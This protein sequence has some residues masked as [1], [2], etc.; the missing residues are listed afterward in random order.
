VFVE[1]LVLM[2][3]VGCGTP[4]ASPPSGSTEDPTSP[5]SESTA[6][7][8]PQTWF[9]DLDGD[10]A[11]DPLSATQACDQPP[12]HTL[13][14][15]DCDDT[16]EALNRD[17]GDG[18]GHSSCD[19]DCDDADPELTAYDVDG[20]GYS[21]CAGDCHDADAALTPEDVDGD[22]A[23]SCAGDC[24]DADATMSLADADGDGASSCAGDC[25]DSDPLLSL[26]DVDGDGASSCAGDCDDTDPELSVADVDGDGLSSCAGDCDDHDA[27]S[28]LDR[29][30]DGFAACDGDC[31]DRDAAMSP[32]D[33]DG[34][35]YSTCDG[36]CDDTMALW[37]PLNG[38]VPTR[39]AAV[40]VTG[41]PGAGDLKQS[42]ALLDLDGDSSLDLLVRTDESPSSETLADGAYLFSGPLA[43]RD[44]HSQ[45]ALFYGSLAH[46]M[47]GYDIEAL[48][49]VNG[50]GFDDAAISTPLTTSTLGFTYLLHG[51][52]TP[53]TGPTDLQTLPV[54]WLEADRA[55]YYYDLPQPRG[56]G[57]LDRDGFDDYAMLHDTAIRGDEET[58]TIYLVHGAADAMMGTRSVDEAD[59]EWHGR[60]GESERLGGDIAA[61]DLNGDD[62]ADLVMGASRAWAGGPGLQGRAYVAYGSAARQVGVYSVDDADAH[63]VGT[64]WNGYYGSR[65]EADFDLDADGLDDFSVGEIYASNLYE[66]ALHFYRGSDAWS[67]GYAGDT[68]AWLTVTGQAEY[69]YMGEDSAVAD[70][71][72]D[73][74]VDLAVSAT[75]LD[76]RRG[77]V[78]V[79]RGPFVG[80]SLTPQDADHFLVG[81]AGG[82]SFGVGLTA[83]DV[84]GSGQVDLAVF[85]YAGPGQVLVFTDD[86]F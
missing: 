30:G 41:A 43:D 72:G 17:D 69:D 22:G 81:D 39:Q 14:G 23:S 73:G 79:Y 9:A 67:G 19:G 11:G 18:D 31:D 68:E 8:E 61:A 25:D 55:A 42:F 16:D 53:A 45:D 84:D 6:C 20:D 36:D 63:L 3:L 78:F 49:D 56:L 32:V 65:I 60:D 24:D 2:V 70:L 35:G 48:G 21:S 80:G 77:A 52:D 83:A 15:D 13:T 51:S 40:R 86:S 50:D 44:A 27:Y 37:S 71:D 28:M 38:C 62:A 75:G 82:D 54:W 59:A 10:G 74:S 7:T 47:A 33:D 1:Y 57:D 76:S 34:D 66:G 46:E 12:G 85:T 26:N 29:D 64:Y 4:P 5:T 58:G